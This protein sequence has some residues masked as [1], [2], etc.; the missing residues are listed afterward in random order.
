MQALGNRAVIVHTPQLLL[1]G[2][3]C[4]FA[5]CRFGELLTS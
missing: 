1:N 2:A 4:W 5:D 3:G